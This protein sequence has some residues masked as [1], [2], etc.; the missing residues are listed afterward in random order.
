MHNKKERKKVLWN[1]KSETDEK[2][3]LFIVSF[4][5]YL[6]GIFFLEITNYF[7]PTF[8]LDYFTVANIN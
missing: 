7:L 3:L 4:Y 8:I 5:I 1:A 2:P 6:I